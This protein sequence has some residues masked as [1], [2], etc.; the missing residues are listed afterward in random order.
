MTGNQADFSPASGV[1][2]IR[3]KRLL[4]F[5]IG[6][7]IQIRIVDENH[8]LRPVRFCFRQQCPYRTF[9]VQS[10]I[11]SKIARQNLIVK[12]QIHT[13]NP[14][15]LE[16]AEI[17][18][19]VGAPDDQILDA[20]SCHPDGDFQLR[21]TFI[22]L[23]NAENQQSVQLP[24][25]AAH[26]LDEASGEFMRKR[27]NQADAFQCSRMSA[28]SIRHAGSVRTPTHN[29]S[30]R[31]ELVVGAAHSHPAGSGALGIF[32]LGGQTVARR[33]FPRKNISRQRGA[34]LF[35]QIL[36]AHSLRS[37]RLIISS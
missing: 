21:L 30:G 14:Q 28:K 12:D 37:S 34:N 27:S 8:L 13:E 11:I 33:I 29:D 2:K 7:H 3:F 36:H 25:A 5:G 15:T 4:A 19:A 35:G 24:A 17:E 16:N 22:R 20:A 32:A 6:I 23:R 18:I 31:F 9:V 26:S 10:D 1:L